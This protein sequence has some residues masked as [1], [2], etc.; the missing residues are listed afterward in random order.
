[1][2]AQSVYT[3]FASKDEIYDAMFRQGYEEFLAWIADDAAAP[4]TPLERVRAQAH[5]FLHRAGEDAAAHEALEHVLLDPGMDMVETG[6]FNTFNNTG[7]QRI[8]G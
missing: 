5:R 6:I 1:M 7:S 3:Y 2:R 8:R 4:R